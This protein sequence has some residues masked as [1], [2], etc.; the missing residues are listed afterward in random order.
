[1]AEQVLSKQRGQ[2]LAARIGELRPHDTYNPKAISNPYWLTLFSDVWE[3]SN[4][5]G[6]CAL[7]CRRHT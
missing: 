4:F 3:K 2:Q 6:F 5:A 7:S 1:M